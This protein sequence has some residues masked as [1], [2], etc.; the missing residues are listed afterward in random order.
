MTRLM[1]SNRTNVISLLLILT[2]FLL[3]DHTSVEKLL[4]QQEEF[5]SRHAFTNPEK[6]ECP[7]S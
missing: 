2:N 7:A 4:L 1:S 6:L 3:L 5:W